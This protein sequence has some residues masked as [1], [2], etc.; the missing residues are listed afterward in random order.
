MSSGNYTDTGG[1]SKAHNLLGNDTVAQLL[2]SA[3]VDND[4]ISTCSTVVSLQV[5]F[6]TIY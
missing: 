4:S 2:V 1:P 5:L 3:L 6:S